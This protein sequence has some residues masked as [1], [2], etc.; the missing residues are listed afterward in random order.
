L[1]PAAPNYTLPPSTAGITNSATPASISSIPSP[2]NFTDV[3][4]ADPVNP[5]ALG[6]GAFGYWN[7]QLPDDVTNSNSTPSPYAATTPAP[8]PFDFGFAFGDM[9]A[10]IPSSPLGNSSRVHQNQASGSGTDSINDTA[11]DMTFPNASVGATPATASARAEPA[12]DDATWHMY[13]Q[14]LFANAAANGGV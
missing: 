14:R 8:V 2:F 9:D 1:T 3:G 13:M 4:M 7:L 5:Y 10:H 12:L 11:F 6:N